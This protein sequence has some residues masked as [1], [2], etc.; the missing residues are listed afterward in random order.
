MCL[1][2]PMRIL[3]IDGHMACCEAK[4]VQRTV[5]LSLLGDEAVAVGDHVLV[6]VGYALQ[7]VSADE[8]AVTWDL[9]D[10]VSLEL[11]RAAG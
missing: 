3:R 10:L 4:A 11:D 5:S 2:V 6:H 7:T 1:A 8:A 9:L